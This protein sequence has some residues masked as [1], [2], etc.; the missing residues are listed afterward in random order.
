MTLLGYRVIILIM[1]FT[2]TTQEEEDSYPLCPTRKY[3]TRP[4]MMPADGRYG[5]HMDDGTI[6][7]PLVQK[8]EAVRCMEPGSECRVGNTTARHRTMCKQTYTQIRLRHV[9]GHIV[10]N[11]FSYPSGCICQIY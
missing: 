10:R 5:F 9:E 2:F 8:V 11:T 6:A 7:S 3:Y 1:I 4:N